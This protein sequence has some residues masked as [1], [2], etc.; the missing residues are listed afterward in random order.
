MAVIILLI[1]NSYV[2][3]CRHMMKSTFFVKWRCSG[4]QVWWIIAW[5]PIPDPIS[6]WAPIWIKNNHPILYA[7]SCSN[8]SNDLSPLCP[9]LYQWMMVALNNVFSFVGHSGSDSMEFLQMQKQI[10]K[11]IGNRLHSQIID[12]INMFTDVGAKTW[13]QGF[14]VTP[15]QAWHKSAW[16]SMYLEVMKY[17]HTL[18]SW[19][20]QKPPHSFIAEDW[21]APYEWF[22]WH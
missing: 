14:I 8:E 22:H 16:T 7:N 10:S 18:T 6:I 1:H 4:Y 12:Y 17:Y 20:I 5:Y 15:N 11:A 19:Y 3:V 13:K 21:W 9:G 2:Y